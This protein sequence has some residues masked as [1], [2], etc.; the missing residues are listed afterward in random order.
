MLAEPADQQK[1][2][3]LAD[4]DA[5]MGRLQH[6]ARSLPQHQRIAEL[7][8]ERQSVADS[9]VE[10]TTIVDDLGV[11][12]RRAEADLVPVR[13]RLER[14]RTRVGDGSISDGK[15]LKGLIDEV[16]RL[17]RRVN[18]LED[19]EFEVMARLEDAESTAKEMSARRDEIEATLRDEVGIRDQKVKGLST[20]AQGVT[21]ARKGVASTVPPALLVM[22]DKI[23]AQRGLAAAK[24]HRGRCTG[25]QLEI[26]VAD[27]DSYRKAP[28]NQVLRCVEC[29]RIL[30]RTADSGL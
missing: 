27:L 4:L 29:D 17:E 8:A 15:T 6:T 10:A 2:L 30:V 18:E 12:L 14:D 3:N 7:M 19:A 20:E 13:A 9:L 23:R 11:A 1:L 25:C 24:L 26:T 21:A 28:A 16:A 5:E 22:Y